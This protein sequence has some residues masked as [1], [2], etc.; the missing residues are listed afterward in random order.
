MTGPQ[1]GPPFPIASLLRRARNAKSPKERHD[2]A[3]FAWEASVRMSVAAFPP[4]D[5]SSLEMPSTGS[6]VAVLAKSARVVEPTSDPDVRAA[7]A[8]L[9]E[10]GTARASRP[11]SVDLKRILEPLPAYRN[12]VIGHGTVQASRFYEEG[13]EALLRGIVGAWEANFFW[14]PNSQ[15]VHLESIAIAPDGRRVGRVLRLDGPVPV[16]ED[17]QGTSGIPD[18]VRPRRLYR[19]SPD[20]WQDLG[21]WMLYD[22]E[23][24]RERVLFFNGR[25]RGSRFL[26]YLG[27]EELRGKELREAFPEIEDEIAR[28]LRSTNA[29]V[30]LD[31]APGGTARIVGYQLLGELGSGSMGVVHLARQL[32][33]DRLVAVKTMPADAVSD[34]V[35]LARFQREIRALGRADHPNV[36]KILASGE[37]D[38][39]P[40]Y[41]M[42]LIDGPDLGRLS[43]ALRES[44]EDFDGALARANAAA[45]SARPQTW[46]AAAAAKHEPRPNDRMPLVKR[47]AALFR[48]AALAVE[49]LHEQGVLHRD[50]KPA[51]LMVA[52]ADARI[53]LMDLGLASVGDAS[54]SIAVEH[55]SLVGTLRYSSPEQLQRNLLQVDRRADVYSL[56]ATFYELFCGQP[57]YDG[58]TEVRLIEQ[59]LREPPLPPSRA[60]PRLPRDLAAILGRAVEKDPKLRYESAR[61]LAADLDAFLDGR[62]VAAR[63]PTLGY[64][65]MVTVRRHRLLA[66]AATAVVM[67]ATA[68]IAGWVLHQGSLRRAAER[69]RAALVLQQAAADVDRDPTEAIAWLKQ[70]PVDGPGWTTAQGIAAEALGRGVARDVFV[71]HSRNVGAVV[72]VGELLASGS[73]DGTVR[74]RN[75]REGTDRILDAH[76]GR[77]LRLAP[78]PD[79][80]ELAASYSSGAV[81]I[82]RPNDA[83]RE[84]RLSAT[85]SPPGALA[86]SPDSGRIAFAGTA[87]VIH[88]AM[89]G[90]G[91]VRDFLGQSD[92]VLGLSYSRDGRLASGGRDHRVV[93]W[94][95]DGTPTLLGMHE[96]QVY[97]VRFSPDGSELETVS[98]DGTARLWNVRDHSFRTIAKHSDVPLFGGWS[99]DGKWVVSAGDDP[100]VRLWDARSDRE[101]DFDAQSPVDAV[102]FSPEGAALAAATRSG[103]VLVWNIDSGASRELLGHGAAARAV[104]FSADGRQ[105]ASASEDRTVRVWPAALTAGRVLAGSDGAIEDGTFIPGSGDLVTADGDGHA[106]IWKEGIDRPRLLSGPSGPVRTVA[107]S[108]DGRRIVGAGAD[109]AVWL[110]DVVTG[111][112]KVLGRHASNVWS[113]A[114]R[115]SGDVI[116]SAGID[117]RLGRFDLEHGTSTL[118]GGPAGGLWSVC[119]EGT[120]AASGGYDGGVWF[121]DGP[122][123]GRLLGRHDGYVNHVACAPNRPLVASAGADGTV[124]IWDVANGGS[125]LVAS[126]EGEA[127]TVSWSPDGRFLGVGTEDGTVS[128]V[129]VDGGERRLG[130]H[131]AKV[132]ALAWSPDGTLLGSAASNGMIRIWSP[133]DGAIRVL[134]G[135]AAP[136]FLAF[137]G[138][139]R[140][141]ASG[142]ESGRVHFWQLDDLPRLPS[143]AEGMQA[144]LTSFTNAHVSASGRISSP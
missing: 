137:R 41:A 65:L 48:D 47:L 96:D 40:Y 79:G 10:I 9:S 3:F 75:L 67:S 70:Y 12:K 77:V 22:E 44:G 8:W 19:R 78:S 105:I 64:L 93:V 39:V 121:W 37:N 128:I 76:A 36:V 21:P 72:F 92:V 2:T 115:P 140:V 62:A 56:G 54:R 43:R 4:G 126:H 45:R 106:A 124:R 102:T 85:S 16:V 52:E 31:G 141:L 29:P 14:P 42:E 144:A 53:V 61:A 142:G 59:I 50:I 98:R 32:G 74:I 120:G 88:V 111:T 13:G 17:P 112:P 123:D 33:L 127:L 116:A 129:E 130:A 97:D 38:G 20:G 139:G 119:F 5:A 82:W 138:D 51:N 90:S 114:Y 99:A 87:G 104:A 69:S 35:A 95:A 117:G 86:W 1:S 113:V 23:E 110:W 136:T 101:I 25:D 108:P 58:D 60:N 81:M 133:A 134:V 24:L 11:A 131:R 143:D 7:C 94:E 30:P 27:G 125:R 71:G 118:S 46:A 66:A 55:T 91:T 80:S 34:A 132:A 122:G 107:A 26:D 83:A 49:H 73:D 63:A 28:I 84:V 15:L 18:S 68:V 6:W 135:D 100:L 109:R 103:R 89:S 57:M